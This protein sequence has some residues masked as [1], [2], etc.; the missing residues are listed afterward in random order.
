MRPDNG[1]RLELKLQDGS[2]ATAEYLLS[3]FS[4]NGDATTR[5]SLDSTNG[6]LELGEWVG[7]PPA[8]WLDA[9]ARSL[10]RTIVRNRLNDGEWPRRV[11]RWRPEPRS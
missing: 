2:G 3:V 1:G 6:S 7:T 10:L 11:T 8:P 5:V 9:F 4:P